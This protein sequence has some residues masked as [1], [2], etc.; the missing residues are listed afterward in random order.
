MTNEQ[1]LNGN[2]LSPN[3][4]GITSKRHLGRGVYR[5]RAK[6]HGLPKGYEP[7]TRTIYGDSAVG[8]SCRRLSQRMAL[9]K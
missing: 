9:G 5:A 6:Q 8:N 4:W 3:H 2:G 1:I 7:A